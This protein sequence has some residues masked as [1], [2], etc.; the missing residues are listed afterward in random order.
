MRK[1]CL[2]WIESSESKDVKNDTIISLLPDPLALWTDLSSPRFEEL[3]SSDDMKEHAPFTV[4]SAIHVCTME[5]QC[6]QTC[7]NCECTKL[8]A[9]YIH[10]WR[11]FL[12]R[13]DIIAIVTIDT[14]GWVSTEPRKHDP[15]KV[16]RLRPQSNGKFEM[17][18]L[19]ESVYGARSAWYSHTYAHEFISD[20]G[21]R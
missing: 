1:L 2:D 12:L 19:E 7:Q 10:H 11:V 3:L 14:N 9:L 16:A 21:S 15:Y 18:Y 17:E 13:T 8:N 6:N 20:S 4:Y 5:I